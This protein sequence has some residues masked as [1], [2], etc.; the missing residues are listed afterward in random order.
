ML[1]NLF[2]TKTGAALRFNRIPIGS[3]DFARNAYSLDGVTND[4]KLKHF[5]I[6]RDEGCLIPY[7]KSAQAVNPEMKFHASP[8][9]PPGWMIE[10]FMT[11]TANS[12]VNYLFLLCGLF[13]VNQ[14]S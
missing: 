5:S 11:S 1:Q 9:S 8:W 10:R 12:R 13:I 6:E 14:C 7:I 2:D 3:S 4:W